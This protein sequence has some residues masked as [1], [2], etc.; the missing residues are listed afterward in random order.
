MP[1]PLRPAI[2]FVAAWFVWL[3]SAGGGLVIIE[4]QAP[5]QPPS[6]P[7]T[8]STSSAS[9]PATPVPD[10][11]VRDPA[12][13]PG[14]AGRSVIR[15]RVVALDGG[16]PLRRVL[17]RVMGAEMRM[18]RS[19]FTD[20]QGKYEFKELPAGRYQLQATKGGFVQ[21]AF[22]QR[23]PLE[24]GRPLQL[25]DGQ[26]LEKVDFHL[27][28]GGVIVG[29]VV[30]ELGEPV[31]GGSVKALVRR[32]MGGQRRLVS[33]GYGQT[34]DIG[35]YRIF[36]LP[37][38][39]YYV[40]AGGLDSSLGAEG[41]TD[42]PSGSGYVP[43]YYPG[44]PSLGEAQPITVNIGAEVSADLQLTPTRVSRI[45]GTIVDQN[46][47][48]VGAAF[49]SLQLRDPA[50]G[51]GDGGFS[52]A[53]IGAEGAF[54]MSNVPPGAYY[55]I[56]TTIEEFQPSGQ[57]LSGWVSI[58]LTGQDLDG[59]RIVTTKGAIV[60]GRVAYEGGT[61]PTNRPGVP[62]FVGCATVE[63]AGPVIMAN[64][65]PGK[66]D[67]QGQFELTGVYRE[68]L[69]H[70][71]P[72]PEGWGI[73]AVTHNSQDVTDRPLGIKDT[74]TIADVTVTL[75]NRLAR[76]TGTVTDA[77]DRPAKDYVVIVFPEDAEKLGPHSRFVRSARADQEGRFRMSG[78]PPGEY[79]A[80]ALDTVEDGAE[81]DPEFLDRIRSSSVPMRLSDD[82]QQ[83]ID[84][85][86]IT[87]IP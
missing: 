19:S 36:G 1:I 86:L 50:L 73:A 41:M 16:T 57:R 9:A 71:F 39:E 49:V 20:A 25:A 45:S 82:G 69:M 2:V 3:L 22:G 66:I 27:P 13:A 83:T 28:R 30:D 59:I 62:L 37:P 14:A 10:A 6:T 15:G 21:V 58:S 40:A 5:V 29:R 70:V 24:Q 11:P 31:T 56:A 4:A 80:A 33:A 61:R 52:T 43:T 7:T 18:P 54:A 67:E 64:A 32:R 84:L 53:S 77:T 87:R 26:T 65:S 55:L 51:D 76:V 42:N 63:G 46:E 60:K 85:K 44:T 81:S 34:N 74:Q 78:L 17:V 12:K 79:L 68:C 48:P 47:R 23:Q 35:Q 72:M 75:T 38:G 8:P